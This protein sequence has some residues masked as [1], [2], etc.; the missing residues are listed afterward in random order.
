[1]TGPDRAA[2]ADRLGHEAGLAVDAVESA[3]ALLDGLEP[4]PDGLLKGDASPVTVADFAV[5]A[6]IASRLGRA[7]PDDPL[8]A[9]EDAA[10]LGRAP[11]LVRRVTAAVQRADPVIGADQVL[12]WIDRGRGTA[13][14]RFWTLDPVD[15]TRGWLRGGQYAV[16]LA[17]V[18]R[19]VVRVAALGCPRLSPG[20]LAASAASHGRGAGGTA[21]AVRGG[22]AW[23]LARGGHELVRLATSRVGDPRRA[24]VL[25]SV[26]ATHSDAAMLG[27]VVA[28]LGIE[29]PPG[30]MDSQAKLLAVAS[31]DAD[32]V[33]RFPIA[34]DRRE[35]I[36]DLAAGALVV[37]EAGGRVT[38]LR[39]RRFDF[40]AGRQMSGH[41]GL[42]VSN[43][44]LH[45][46]AL[47]A[48]ADL[49][50]TRAHWEHLPHDADVGVVGVGPTKAE[51]FRQ[52]ALALTA[53]VTEPDRV[54]TVTPVA[55]D[56]HAANDELLLVE[57]LNALI[58]EMAVRSML[59]ADFTVAIDDAGLHA[60]AI[61]E[62]V[63]RERHQPAVEPKGATMT[64]LRVV[65]GPD[66]WRAQCVVDV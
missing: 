31:G 3:L 15:G 26:E 61:G 40:A 57:W 60:T 6:V 1:M 11:D 63:D 10:A 44:A 53:I 7:R 64:A 66:G 13:G 19:G 9:E 43:G 12:A 18:E 21:V 8:V 37:E 38:D 55:L 34:P 65:Q 5:Q 4:A 45:D 17:L 59:F 46:A 25:H 48:V 51:A 22:G 2:V 14:G 29:A 27:R 50:A 39:G 33:F 30:L 56:C 52:A 58:Y 28:A 23:W 20:Q 42:V 32:L 36:W 41:E 54:R 62:P 35:P 49:R 16:A 24:R 47:A